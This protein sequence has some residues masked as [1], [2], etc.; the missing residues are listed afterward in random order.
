[1]KDYTMRLEF[2]KRENGTL[3]GKI[4]LALPDKA[5]SFVNGTFIAEIK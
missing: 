2:G 3:P 1:M 4:F 5:Q